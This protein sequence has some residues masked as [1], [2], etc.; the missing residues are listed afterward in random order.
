MIRAVDSHL[1][2]VD[3]RRFPVVP[4]VGYT[5]ASPREWGTLEDMEKVFGENGITHA[6]IVQPS[7]YGFDNSCMLDAIA[8]G[9]GRY[10]GIAVVDPAS[11]ADEFDRLARQ[12]IVGVRLNMMQSD[13]DSLARP[14]AETFLAEVRR[15]GWFLQVFAD[16]AKWE[17]HAERLA[18]TGLK[19]MVDHFGA[20]DCTRGVDQPGFQAV[21][22]A[23]RTAGNW[24]VKLSAP[25]RVSKS[26]P[27]F[28]DL[29]PF[30][31][32]LVA[33]F[34]ADGCVWGSDWPYLNVGREVFYPDVLRAVARWFPGDEERRRLMRDNPAR[35]F[36]F[37]AAP[38]PMTRP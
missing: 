36:G 27:D 12:G 5:P 26:Y 2:V 31:A 18:A 30:V 8:R 32:E 35:L 25:F 37:D 23:A 15:L 22:R 21:L 29:D 38:G 13:P 10:R 24:T 3:P 11:P 16:G 9:G 33:A 4:G 14:E 28:G 6:L 7:C 20:P 17:R 1:H 19:V 34:G